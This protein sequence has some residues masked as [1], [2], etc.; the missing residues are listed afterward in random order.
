MLS[1][2]RN[3]PFQQD[4][5]LSVKD[6]YQEIDQENEEPF[7]FPSDMLDEPVQAWFENDQVATPL[8]LLEVFDRLT[9]HESTL[10]S[11]PEEFLTCCRDYLLSLKP[12]VVVSTFQEEEINGIDFL[13]SDDCWMTKVPSFVKLVWFHAFQ[14]IE[15]HII[16]N[17]EDIVVDI[18][19]QDFSEATYTLNQFFNGDDFSLYV[20]VVFG[21]KKGTLPQQAIARKLATFIYFGF[22]ER[23]KSIVRQDEICE[24]V[25]FDVQEMSD[26]GLSKVRHVGGWAV[27]KVLSH[28]RRYVQK[29]VHTNSSCTLATFE[30]QQ[31]VCE[32]LEENINQKPCR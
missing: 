17:Q 6:R 14:M 13:L 24:P 20:C 22:L 7:Q 26:V 31:R 16:E 19:R 5:L 23:L 25:A 8:E 28:A 9:R 32:P 30:N 29:N 27:R 12:S 4:D 1:S 15:N 21:A 11:P 3:K 10:S 2:C 18:G